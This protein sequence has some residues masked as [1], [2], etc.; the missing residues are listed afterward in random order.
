MYD[1]PCEVWMSIFELACD[2]DG[3]TG[4]ALSLVSRSINELS[5]PY[6]LQ[7]IAIIGTARLVQFCKLLD[8]L[9]ENCCRV[10]HF[11][12]S[13]MGQYVPTGEG[14][15]FV[16]P[17]AESYAQSRTAFARVLKR[18]APYVLTCTIVSDIP[19]IQIIFSVSLPHM[20]EATLHGPFPGLLYSQQPPLFP[21]LRKVTF[22]SFGSHPLDLFSDIAAQ[23]PNLEEVAFHPSQP[24]R[25]LHDDLRRALSVPAPRSSNPLLAAPETP[26]KPQ[27]KLPAGVKSITIEPGPE[28]NP[29]DRN[30]HFLR[31]LQTLMKK[32]VAWIRK[33]DKRVTL[34]PPGP[35]PADNM[36][37]IRWLERS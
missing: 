16:H 18:I 13:N 12:L 15:K 32:K 24:S 25:D 26:C 2:D 5:R 10:R 23:I 8:S 20:V 1:C 21:A 14:L 3:S 7:S 31:T 34:L 9:P 28:I 19:R 22:S 27:A 36:G 35:A 4:R 17:P 11:F 30:A 37:L 33:H 6:K 29:L